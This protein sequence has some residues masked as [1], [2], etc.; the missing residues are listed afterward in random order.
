[1]VHWSYFQKSN[2]IKKGLLPQDEMELR[3]DDDRGRPKKFP[4]CDSRARNS[5]QRQHSTD[6]PDRSPDHCTTSYYVASAACRVRPLDWSLTTGR[7]IEMWITDSPRPW[8]LPHRLPPPWVSFIRRLVNII[9]FSIWIKTKFLKKSFWHLTPSLLK[10]QMKKLF[11]F[12]LEKK[13]T[14]HK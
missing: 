9:S 13:Y 11:F 8:P 6:P 10:W 5:T 7:I 2:E 14:H 3:L 1:M 4:L 12:Y